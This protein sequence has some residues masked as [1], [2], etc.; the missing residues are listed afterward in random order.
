M[1]SLY[2]S[3]SALLLAVGLLTL[4]QNLLGTLLAVRMSVEGFSVLV[5][6]LV[7]AGYFTGLLAGSLTVH[8]IIRTVGHIRVLTALISGFSAATLVHALTIDPWS[9][10]ALRF[11]EGYCMAGIYICIESWLNARSTNTTRG[12]VFGLYMVTTYLFGGLAQFLLVTADV[13]GFELFSVASLL[14]SVALLPVALTRAPAPPIPGRSSIGLRR[15]WQISPLGTIGCTV[16]GILLGAYYGMAPRYGTAAG[17]DAWGIATFMGAGIFGGMALQSPIGWLS[18]RYDR[19]LVLTIVAGALALSSLLVAVLTNH[20]LTGQPVTGSESLSRIDL[21]AATLVFGG[22]MFVV[23]PLAVSHV[24]DRAD[25]S[26]YVG[27]SG[28]MILLYS[29]GAVFGPII[30]SAS[31]E[32]VGP[33]GLFLSMGAASALLCAYAVWRMR[34]TARPDDDS[35]VRFRPSAR[36]A[37]VTPDPPPPPTDVR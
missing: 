6:G 2:A 10:T 26:E 28:G 31:M 17:M 11:A 9:W 4:G 16:S 18:D 7:M 24:N 14:L 33:A 29:I 35:R 27:V 32:A 8:G 21:L 3:L 20:S 15:L 34:M 1:R 23:Y 22:L 30:A 13:S 5:S 19:R 37:Q 25:P 12:M 36:V